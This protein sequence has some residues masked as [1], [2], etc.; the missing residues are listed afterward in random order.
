MKFPTYPNLAQRVTFAAALLAMAG[1]SFLGK[2]EHTH[3]GSLPPPATPV[4]PVPG[5]PGATPPPFPVQDKKFLNNAARIFAYERR[6]GAVARQYGN[7]DDARNLGSLME[8]EMAL[9]A[10]NLKAL[11][12]ARQQTLDSGGWGHGGAER[13]A[14]QRGGDFDR[15]FYEE[16]KLSSPEAYGVFDEAFRVIADGGIKEFAKNWYPIL[17]NYPREAI[18]LEMQ[19]DKKH[20]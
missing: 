16:V 18:K 19:R 13:L 7:S 4:P 9:A 2:R 15:K 3:I 6:L 20:K 8:A 14:S 1:C 5:A 17:R 10:V 12:D 11:A